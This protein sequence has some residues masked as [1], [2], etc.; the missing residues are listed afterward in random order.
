[1][2]LVRLT[3]LAPGRV[4]L[5]RWVEPVDP[6]DPVEVA[7]LVPASKAAAGPSH[8]CVLTMLP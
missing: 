1:L 6:A 4:G 2:G 5:P 8:Q 3:G 7:E